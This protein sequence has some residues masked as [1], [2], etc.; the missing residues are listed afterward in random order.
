VADVTSTRV[1]HHAYG[2][3]IALWGDAMTQPTEE[4]IDFFSVV[5]TPEFREDPYTFFDALRASDP[6]HHTPFGVY[7]LSRHADATAV[8]RDPRLSNDERNSELFRTFQETNPIP[9]EQTLD[10]DR[11]V[12]LFLDPPDH[13]RLR[14]LVSKGFTPRMVERL[15]ARI[16]QIVDERLDAVAARGD[17]HMDVVTDLAYPLPVEIICELL[18]VPVEDQDTF[19][20]WSGELAGAI[21]PDPLISPEQRARIKVAGDAFIEYFASL[22]EQRRAQPADDLLSAMIAAEDDGDRL[23]EEELLG[24]A[25]FL[26]IAGHETTVNLIGNGTLALLRHPDQL[27]RLRRDPSLD[28]NAVEEL[29]R[30]DSPVQITQR[31]TVSDYD[32]GGVTIPSG[33]NLVPLL[34]AAN[35]DPAVFPE[36]DRLDLRRE[37]AHRHVAFGGGHHFCLGAAL[38]RLEGAIAIGSL[39]RRFPSIELAGDPERRTTFTLRGLEHL[40]VTVAHEV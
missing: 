33:Q 32:V 38:A 6:I 21:D 37:N 24:T 31:I 2:R 28:R 17:G 14:G 15:R 11:V 27:E 3:V 30:Y 10:M 20:S 16:Q 7:L 8:V 5:M 22:I 4:A 13:T 34:G 29:L 9:P 25:L 36:P 35:R 40:P 26:L 1:H 12:M 19:A 23:N 39:V 18:G